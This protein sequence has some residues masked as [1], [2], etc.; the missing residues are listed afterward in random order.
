MSDFTMI[1]AN[2]YLETAA[3]NDK[4]MH[5]FLFGKSNSVSPYKNDQR[6]FFT[7]VFYEPN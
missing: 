7:L 4:E 6:S 5:A 2:Y 1:D 3:W